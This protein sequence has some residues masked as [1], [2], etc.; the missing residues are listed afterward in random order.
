MRD[1]S[2]ALENLTSFIRVAVAS[3]LVDLGMDS[4]SVAAALLHDV[5]EDTDVSLA[6]LEKKFGKSI[7]QIVNGVTKLT[8]L[9]TSTK[10]ELQAENTEKC[11]LP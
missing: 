8:Q 1:K 10:A 3:I 6:E 2:A 7:A 5:V 9:P 4:E 11:F